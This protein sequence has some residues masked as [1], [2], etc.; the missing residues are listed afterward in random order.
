VGVTQFSLGRYQK[1]EWIICSKEANMDSP[2][3][4]EVYNLVSI[5]DNKLEALAA[6]DKYKGDMHG[7][8]K[9]L[10]ETLRADDARHAEMLA[11]AL[12]TIARNDGLRKK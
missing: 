4:N 12:E 9:D 11:T 8:N 7:T 2:L 5:L 10:V 3:S 6:Y 1:I